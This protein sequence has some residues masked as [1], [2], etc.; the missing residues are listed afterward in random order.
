MADRTFVSLG[1][2]LNC[3]SLCGFLFIVF[4]PKSLFAIE[5]KSLHWNGELTVGVQASAYEFES[6]HVTEDYGVKIGFEHQL[7]E[8]LGLVLRLA[9]GTIGRDYQFQMGAP[10]EP[11]FARRTLGLDRAYID[12][13]LNSR[14]NLIAGRIFQPQFT[15]AKSEVL[16][17]QDFNLEG[18]A[19]KSQ[20]N[21]SESIE[22]FMSAMSVL[23][24][25]NYEADDLYYSV[26]QTDN[27]L[28]AIQIGLSSFY[29]DVRYK[30]GA[31]FYNFTSIQNKSFASFVSQGQAWGNTEST[32]GTAK[33]EY[34]PREVFFETSYL[35][36]DL[37][38][39]WGFQYLTNSETDDPHE[40]LWT[41][42]NF[43]YKNHDFQ[44]A[45]GRIE[46]DVV[47][48]AYT[49]SDFGVG[50]T[51]V[52]GLQFSWGYVL[53]KGLTSRLKYLENNLAY[54]KPTHEDYRRLRLELIA[55]F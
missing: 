9:V 6:D 2:N 18:A 13:Q 26:E 41:G 31:G 14:L 1:V 12:W 5:S 23:L 33:N 24:R 19:L 11:G 16:L 8:N 34:V 17:D 32:P 39:I 15:A 52:E 7:N 47:P 51:D 35:L 42:M 54:S 28:N 43:M 36:S 25:E 10:K 50:R 29:K 20:F 30:F 55:A 21:I 3:K 22:L 49:Q 48:A 46:S 53:Q 44:I 37:K 45:W 4:L 38:I 27:T 40:S